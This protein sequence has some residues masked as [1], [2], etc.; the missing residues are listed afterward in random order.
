[1]K[2]A[3]WRVDSDLG[4]LYL[5]ASEKGLRGIFWK[6][7]AAPMPETL[8]S[9]D[10][11]IRVL[12]Q[13]VR[14]LESYLTGRLKKFRLPLDPAGTDFQKKV[15]RELVRIPYG[16]TRSYKDVARLIKNPKAFRAVGTA[17]GQNPLCIV[18]PCHRVIAADG[19]IGGYSG[20]LDKKIKLLTLERNTPIRS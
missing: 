5:V 19:S 16:Q 9:A 20:G 4:P 2:T 15:W 1:M 3:Q 12:S 8:K 11:E 14:Q 7:Q 6:K 10:R 17:N 13:S 18:V